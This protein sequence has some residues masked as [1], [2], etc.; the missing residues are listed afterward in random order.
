MKDGKRKTR[1]VVEI[2]AMFTIVTAIMLAIL[3]GTILYLVDQSI[4]KTQIELTREIA[5]ARA[6]AHVHRRTAA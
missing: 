6:S 5:A 1:L 2:S 3:T 4:L